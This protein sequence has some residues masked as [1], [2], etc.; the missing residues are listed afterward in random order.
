MG[1]TNYYD[2]KV[3]TKLLYDSLLARPARFNTLS[4]EPLILGTPE[5]S[6][7]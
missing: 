1:F 3:A 6:P 2:S 7:P 4:V 5:A